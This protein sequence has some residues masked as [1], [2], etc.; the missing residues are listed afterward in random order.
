MSIIEISD[1]EGELIDELQSLKADHVSKK[2]LRE[3]CDSE[4]IE[5]NVRLNNNEISLAENA[6]VK[7]ILIKLIFKFCKE[8]E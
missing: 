8:G 7:H 5:A 6:M 4:N 2:A 1:L 3:W